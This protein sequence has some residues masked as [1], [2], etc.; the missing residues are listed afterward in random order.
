[1]RD[2]PDNDKEDA[3]GNYDYAKELSPTISKGELREFLIKVASL[4]DD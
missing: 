2:N 4:T 3:I 1:V